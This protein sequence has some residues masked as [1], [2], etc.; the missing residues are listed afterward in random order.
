MIWLSVLAALTMLWASMIIGLIVTIM[1]S[2]RTRRQPTEP[3][4]PRYLIEA[5]TAA[6]DL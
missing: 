3:L 5:L 6:K 2:D 4:I 1:I